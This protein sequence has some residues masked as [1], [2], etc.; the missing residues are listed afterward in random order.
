MEQFFLKK[1]TS[2]I[3]QDNTTP[4]LLYVYMNTAENGKWYRAAHS[5]E[6]ICEI[7]I[8]ME[9]E[10][11]Y[12]V[13]GKELLARKGDFIVMNGGIIHEERSFNPDI[14]VCCIGVKNLFLKGRRKNT[15]IDNETSPLFSGNSYSETV[16]FMIETIY[17]ALKH[18]QRLCMDETV[19]HLM[20]ALICIVI[21]AE[22]KEKELHRRSAA[23]DEDNG[24]ENRLLEEIKS[25]IDVH[26][27]ESFSLD[28]LAGYFFIGKY[29]MCHSF[30]EK[31]GCSIIDY[32]IGC[33]IGEAQTLL[34][35]TDRRISYIAAETGYS[36]A[37]Y[38]STQ[39]LKRVG[40]TPFE[41]RAL[42]NAEKT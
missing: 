1:N 14:K 27:K 35:E 20:M 19:Q 3:F 9:G 22:Q 21:D 16:G 12:T 41:Y 42:K 34:L 5:H 39:F 28:E 24:R 4:H 13:N 15:I 25:Y 7:S 6:N 18:E 37:G 8:V 10:V 38:F 17:S 40:K 30:K 33:R 11:Y 32:T 26:Y 29:H 2:T 31:Y 23:D 36:S